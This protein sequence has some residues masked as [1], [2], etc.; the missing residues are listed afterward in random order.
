MVRPL[1][2]KP[3]NYH[4]SC[5]IHHFSPLFPFPSRQPVGCVETHPRRSP[6]YVPPP[7]DKLQFAGK[8]HNVPVVPPH[9]DG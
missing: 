8:Q 5:F 1:P 3:E 4:S 2:V 7:T 9:S 6:Q